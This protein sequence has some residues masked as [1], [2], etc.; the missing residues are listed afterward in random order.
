MPTQKLNFTVANSTLARTERMKRNPDVELPHGIEPELLDA[1]QV[2]ALL[3]VDTRTV[4]RLR[5]RGELPDS[6]RFGGNVRWR[7]YEILK[8]IEQG[9]PKRA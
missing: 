4:F 1:K 8:W 9:C 6:V 3:A 2:A 7:R 5:L